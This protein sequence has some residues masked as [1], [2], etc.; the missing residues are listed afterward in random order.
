MITHG[1]KVETLRK[2]ERE[3]G[4]LAPEDVVE[5]ARKRDSPIHDLFEW[6]N[7][8]AARKYR[9]VQ[10]A[11]LIRSVRFNLTVGEIPLTVP[12]YVRDL[13]TETTG[14][15]HILEVRSDEDVNRLTVLDA[16]M[17][18][19]NAFKRAKTL[20]MAFEIEDL[21]DQAQSLIGQIVMR[22]R[23]VDD[24]PEGEA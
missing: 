4:H 11:Q 9:L 15:R 2:L 13:R 20:A 5:E 10:A 23:G 14:Y 18:A 3:R 22:T 7:T 19:S 12:R 21:V 17:R 1:D 16:M 24:Q 8:E 6:N